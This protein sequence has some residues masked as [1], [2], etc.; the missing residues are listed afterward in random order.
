[1]I[2]LR[3]SSGAVIVL[4]IAPAIPPH[5]RV[6]KGLVPGFFSSGTVTLSPISRPG[7]LEKLKA[8]SIF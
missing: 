5:K 7:L 1:M 8:F 4:E 3:R 2:T 6:T